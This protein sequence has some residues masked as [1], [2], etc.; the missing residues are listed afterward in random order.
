MVQLGM[1]D[2]TG[3]GIHAMILAQ[4]RRYF[5]LPD[6]SKSSANNVVVKIFGRAIDENYSLLLLERQELDIDT[7][8]A[9]DRVQKRLHITNEAAARLRRGGLIEGRKPNY[10]VSAQVAAATE[11]QATYTRNRGL[12]KDQLK[13]FVLNHLAQFKTATREK[14]D[15]LL[16]PMLPAGLTDEQ[17]RNKVKNLLNE[18]GTQD[19]LIVCDGKGPGALWRLQGETLDES[20]L[21]DS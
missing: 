5:P 1:I 2:T 13:Q 14:L 16:T 21:D 15:S 7:V 18:M 19:R 11:T 20:G 4:R 9:L 10:Y 6:Y 3:Y 8:I 12:E 17:K